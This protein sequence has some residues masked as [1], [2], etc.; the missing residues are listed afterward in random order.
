V[1]IDPVGNLLLG[2]LRQSQF[3]VLWWGKVT[4]LL[5]LCP[6]ISHPSLVSVH[7]HNKPSARTHTD[8]HV[9]LSAHKPET[10]DHVSLKLLVV[11]Q[12]NH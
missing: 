11:S 4:T 10:Q 8:L 6:K 5:E 12:I 7:R 9:R 2:Q 3:S 1:D